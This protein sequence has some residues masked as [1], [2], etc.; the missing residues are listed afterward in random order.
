M[1]QRSTLPIETI[2]EQ[3]RRNAVALI[4][5]LVAFTALG[6]NTWRN[7]T[8]EDQRNLRSAAFRSLEALGEFEQIVLW[9][10]YFNAQASDQ[11][12]ANQQRIAGYGQ[13]FLIRDLTSLLPP[14]APEAGAGLATA[15]DRHV[16]ALSE[17]GTQRQQARSELNTA[18]DHTRE[19]VLEVL[20]ALD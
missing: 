16:D 13:A 6:Y 8:T 17:T 9:R 3:I 5:L 20:Q 10:G 14:P 1:T 7:E 4:S 15:W 18:I 19:T 2:R 11:V 12:S